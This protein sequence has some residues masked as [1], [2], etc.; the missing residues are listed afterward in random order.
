M[1]CGCNGIC[2]CNQH[3]LEV[4]S[5]VNQRLAVPCGEIKAG[6]ALEPEFIN[7]G[8]MKITCRCCENVITQIATFEFGKCVCELVLT[9]DSFVG[10][11]KGQYAYEII[12]SVTKDEEN[13]T[14]LGSQGVIQVG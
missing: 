7:S 1:N 11:P 9:P 3:F 8:V 13:L 10:I 4:K 14:I 2:R 12:W 6:C 5:G